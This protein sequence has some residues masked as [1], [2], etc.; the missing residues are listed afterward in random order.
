[1]VARFETNIK[2]SDYQID[3]MNTSEWNLY[4]AALI[5]LST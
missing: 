3:V 5:L 1:M 2:L 4:A